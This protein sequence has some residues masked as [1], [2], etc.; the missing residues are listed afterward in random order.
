[1]EQFETSGRAALAALPFVKYDD[2][3]GALD[4]WAPDRNGDYGS[5]CQAG[6]AFA[7]AA[8]EHM[9]STAAPI[10]LGNIVKQIIE[11]AQYDGVEVGFFTEISQAAMRGL[12]TA[13]C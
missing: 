8:I 13:E 11:R 4:L 1:M 6:R 12:A 7:Q 10:L 5:D 9:V 2:A 3:T